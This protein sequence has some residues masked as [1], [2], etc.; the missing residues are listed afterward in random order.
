MTLITAFVGLGLVLAGCGKSDTSKA[1][2]PSSGSTSAAT[3]QPQSAA[4]TQQSVPPEWIAKSRSWPD[5]LRWTFDSAS[6]Y[7]QD[8]L[9]MRLRAE[10]GQNLIPGLYNNAKPLQCILYM[11]LRPIPEWPLARGLA[12]DSAIIRD[13]AT[14]K[15]FPTLRIKPA[16]RS[17]ES[18]T[19]RTSYGT[20]LVNPPTPDVTEGQLMQPTIYM[21]WDK[22]QIVAVLPPSR[23]QYVRGEKK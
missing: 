19:V 22:R 21:H 15:V 10:I 17:F 8:G 4:G 16:E 12:I 20:I 18:Q 5:T 6:E 2:V 3:A 13:V 23:L 14:A 9:L 7:V 1:G 11:T